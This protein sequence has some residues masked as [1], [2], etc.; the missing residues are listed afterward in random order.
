MPG[1]PPSRQRTSSR[2]GGALPASLRAR[3]ST[4]TSGWTT[5]PTFML[6]ITSRFLWK[7]RGDPVRFPALAVDKLPAVL[8]LLHRARSAARP[9][10]STLLR[11]RQRSALPHG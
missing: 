3:D 1:G 11:G 7:T 9:T 6:G 4:S 5:P 10:E 2:T 8:A